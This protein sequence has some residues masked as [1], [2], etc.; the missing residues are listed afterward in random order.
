VGLKVKIDT[1]AQCNVI[2]KQKYLT[3]SKTSLQRSKAKLTA[4][5]VINCIVVEKPSCPA[6]AM[7][8]ST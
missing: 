3:M 6:G 8:T 1:S 7:V 4:L 2:S 5:E